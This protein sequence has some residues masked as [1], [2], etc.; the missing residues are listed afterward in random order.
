MVIKNS[1]VETTQINY[2]T[3]KFYNVIKTVIFVFLA[4]S[5]LLIK[6]YYITLKR[7]IQN[8]DDNYWNYISV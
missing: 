5:R 7:F 1:L 4:S 2:V 6:T 3:K 8:I